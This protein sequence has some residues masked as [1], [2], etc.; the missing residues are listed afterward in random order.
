MSQRSLT[1][2]TTNNSYRKGGGEG[3]EKIEVE[4]TRFLKN[5]RRKA[6][7]GMGHGSHNGQDKKR[8]HKKWHDRSNRKNRMTRSGE[9]NQKGVQRK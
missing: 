2:I 1:Y 4:D 7:V 6:V 5:T 3:A 8:R 9:N